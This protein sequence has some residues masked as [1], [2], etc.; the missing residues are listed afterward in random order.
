MAL[1]S[2]ST[3]PCFQ[4]CKWDCLGFI[5]ND[6][7]RQFTRPQSTGLSGLGAMLESF[8]SCNTSQKQ[9]PSFKMRFN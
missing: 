1:F 7:W 6:E 2:R 9:F 4:F 5:A 3:C 8:R